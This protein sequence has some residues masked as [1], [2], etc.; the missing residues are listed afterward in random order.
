[1]RFLATALLFSLFACGDDD[2]AL[3]AAVDASVDSA[4]DAEGDAEVDAPP[5]L[6]EGSDERE[7]CADRNPLRNPYFGDLHVHTRYSFDAAAY[8]VR[9]GPRDAYRFARGEEIDLPPYDADGN[10]TRSLRLTRP[11]DFAAVTDHA[12]LIG[13]TS[14]CTNPDSPAYDSSTCEGYRGGNADMADFGDF[15]SAIGL[16]N[17]RP[18]LLCRAQPELCADAFDDAWEDSLNAA[19]EFYDRSASCEF[20]TFNAYEW[21]GADGGL[22]RNLHRNVIFRGNTVLRHPVSYLDANNEELLWDALDN[23]CLQSDAECDV[24]AIPHNSNISLGN[25]FDLQRVGGGDYDRAFAE[26]R[27]MLE[28]LVEIYQHKGASECL[29]GVDDP[30]ASEDE[31]CSFE[32]FQENICAPGEDPETTGCS[33]ICDGIGEG[34]SFLGACVSVADT[35]RGALRRGLGEYTRIGA[36][37]FQLGFIASTDTHASLA[38]GTEEASW[39]GHVGDTDDEPAELLNPPGGVLVN[40]RTASPG[41]LAVVWA[42]ENS[43][44]AL[45]DAMRRRETYATSGTRPLVRVFGGAIPEGVCE[46]GETIAM[47][48]AA[49]VPMGGVLAASDSAPRFVVS[50][51]RDLESAPINRVQLIKGWVNPETGETEEEIFD[52]L[53]IEEPDEAPVDLSTCSRS[54]AWDSAGLGDGCVTF[55]DPDFDPATPAFYYVRILE[56]PTCRWSQ[57]ICNEAGVDCESPPD[58]PALAGCCDGSLPA[59]VRERA[60]TSPIW[61]LP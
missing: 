30:L 40:V 57:H 12:E 31:F 56:N 25:M 58:D 28:P 42:E 34:S 45:F 49:G 44:P 20:T 35:V 47:A 4:Q 7:A 61:H 18:P 53:V 6:I 33:P 24:L 15:F 60:W 1:M 16:P 48:D 5:A 29:S 55:E 43:R 27:A 37:P 2:D 22:G 38:G 39:R 9:T 3:D 14:L 46:S 36:N 52:L 19:E 41:G 23:L 32:L 8:D 50:V 54:S 13:A 21:T 59:T 17:P 51:S 11:L 26:R 10:A